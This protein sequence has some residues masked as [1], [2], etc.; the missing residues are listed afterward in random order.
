M[1]KKRSII[2]YLLLLFF[3]VFSGKV[4][5]AEIFKTYS[6]GTTTIK[7]KGL[8]A[9]NSSAG[10]GYILAYPG[11]W[12][13]TTTP[14]AIGISNFAS[15]PHVWSDN[16]CTLSD[17][18]TS[19]TCEFVGTGLFQADA[20]A[21]PSQ[22]F[23]IAIKDSVYT[24]GDTYVYSG[25]HY[26]SSTKTLQGGGGTSFSWGTTTSDL[27]SG[28]MEFLNVPELL[29][30]RIPFAY[31]F[32]LTDVLQNL[33]NYATTSI[34]DAG[35]DWKWASGSPAEKTLHVDLFSTTTIGALISPTMLGI[36]RNLMVVVTYFGTAWMLYHE[37]K[38]K[39]LLT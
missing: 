21:W 10:T 9:L 23:W 18:N 6:A 4:Y 11:T 8:H 38:R 39:H 16:G 25:F 36:M 30:T 31:F 35:F 22:D 12:P 17:S 26:T 1:K 29:K 27:P 37:A 15:A 33:D 20:N 13:S 34:P 19:V 5:G 32:Q 28:F 7:F 24:E 14:T 3:I 2:Y